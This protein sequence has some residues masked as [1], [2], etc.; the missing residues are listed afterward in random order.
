MHR[1]KRLTLAAV[2]LGWI[3]A[4]APSM[5][6][7]QALPPDCGSLASDPQW[8]L[9]GNPA[10]VSVTSSQLTTGGR[11]YCRVDVTWSTPGL[12]GP[13]HGYAAGESQSVRIVISLPLRGAVPE[14]GGRLI[15][16]AGGG[17]QGSVPG[18]T[19]MI[20]MNPPAMGAGTDSGHVGGTSF[21]VI[22]D[23]HTLNYGK[24]ADWAEGRA[25]GIAVKLAKQL[26]R[27]Y[28]GGPVSRTYWNGCSG[29]GHMGWAQMQNF[30]EEYDGA[31][32]GAAANHWQ[33]FRL[34]D[35]WDEVVRKKLSQQTGGTFTS[36]QLAA[37]NA[38]ATAA[39][40]GA[41][42]VL[43]GIV[44]DP[45]ACTWSATNNICGAPN[46][47]A[48]PN[49]LTPAQA[50]AIDTMWDGPRNSKGKR[51]WHAYDR[52]IN[53]GTGTSTQGSTNQVLQW[54]HADLTF[55]GNNL[56]Q[57]QESIDLAAAA[58]VDVSNAVTYEEAAWLVS[59]TTADFADTDDPRLD[60][61]FHRGVKI[62]TYH[63]MQDGAIY[64]RNSLD[65][66]RRVATY[67]GNG[68]A[69]FERLREWYR[70]FLTPGAGHCGNQYPGAL[71]A[72][73]DWVENG[74]APDSLVRTTGVRLGCPFPQTAIYDG[75]GDPNDPN[76]FTCG[77]DLDA[78]LVA[79]C[80]MPRLKPKH[81]LTAAL[82][83][84]ET[85]I[86]PGLCQALERKAAK[87]K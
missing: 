16:T 17:A 75:V 32:I 25:N 83:T 41:D 52:G 76:S 31:L 57:D 11:P 10:V 69:D 12:S 42:G 22:Q 58:G 78:N 5:A 23:T 34:A 48:A 64:F 86:P 84:S 60:R 47:P 28:Y 73:M 61:A 7:A 38:A 81:E 49:C 63:G 77:G 51:I 55:D 19:S 33:K 3:A 26:A 71:D 18:V 27:T 72:V 85:A 36:A 82:N 59:L 45:R 39:C 68:K 14:W 40:D 30:P 21:G 53:L 50:A 46:A 66:Y 65:Y 74:V 35:S 44:A 8:G 80:Q 37:A 67:F 9:L 4:L 29:G 79:L 87:A 13:E 1:G 6:A 70:L 24:I 2:L 54:A 43:D 15:M 62:I 20:G 56:Y